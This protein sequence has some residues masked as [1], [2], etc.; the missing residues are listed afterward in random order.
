LA[1]REASLT[2]SVVVVVARP[3]DA[4]VSSRVDEDGDA[5]DNQAAM[6]ARALLSILRLSQALARL[7]FA[8][9]V[10]AEDVD[11]AIRLTYMSKASLLDVAR[12]GGSGAGG[13]GK[14]VRRGGGGWGVG[15]WEGV[16]LS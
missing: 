1:R 11:E 14:G 7:R 9:A 10:A 2:L 12:D 8:T 3:Q 13:G 6:T 16:A 4:G 15:A 5:E